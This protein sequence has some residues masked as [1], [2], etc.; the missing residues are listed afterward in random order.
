MQEFPRLQ[1]F[2]RVI[3]IV[4]AMPLAAGQL[5]INAK[6]PLRRAQLATGGLELERLE[7]AA[8]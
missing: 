1:L 6:Q 8:V 2:D 3:E 5:H 4:G 7:L